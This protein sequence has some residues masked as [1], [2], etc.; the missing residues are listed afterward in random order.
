MVVSQ[1]KKEAEG[2]RGPGEWSV[3]VLVVVSGEF[4]EQEGGNCEVSRTMIMRN[5]LVGR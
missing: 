2:L 1:E 3:M 5:L 4:E